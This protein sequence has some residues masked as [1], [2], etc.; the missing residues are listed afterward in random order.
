VTENPDAGIRRYIAWISVALLVVIVDQATKWAI[1]EWVPLYGKVP[2]NEFMNLTHQQN[3]GAAF[4]FLAGASGWQRWFFVVLATG[5]STVIAVWLWRI[6][7]EAP[8]ILMA[9]L[10][11][12]LGGAVGNLIDRARL[13]Y[14]TDFL[15][16]WFGNWAFPSFNVADAGIS[17]GAALL[18]IDALFVSGRQ[19]KKG[20]EPKKGSDP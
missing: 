13:G 12:V 16:V 7:K 6:R 9:G 1:I 2:L 14:V 15:Q 10:S 11:L 17:V 3:T 5:V 20:S 18:I 4:S 19:T 8:L